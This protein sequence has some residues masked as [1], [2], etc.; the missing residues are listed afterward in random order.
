MNDILN[1]LLDSAQVWQARQ[2]ASQQ[3]GR[4]P[5]G[6]PQL[7]IQLAGGWPQAG[8]I[9]VL[10]GKSGIG[11]LQ[12]LLPLLR[13]CMT[14]GPVLWINPPFIPYA[15]ALNHQ[16]ISLRQ[17]AV[18]HTSSREDTLWTLEHSLRC[19]AVSLVVAWTNSLRSA[20]LRRVQLAAETRQCPCVLLRAPS[21]AGSS[22][23]ATL[24]LL[25][26]SDGERLQVNILKRRGSWP[27]SDLQ[28]PLTNRLP[29][30][31]NSNVISGPWASR[32]Q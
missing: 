9:E 2:Q 18:V 11:E 19:S 27:V 29:H 23:P 22:S 15:P 32:I 12:L 6:F 14:Q 13:Q 1:Q 30:P 8:L 4:M 31:D 17:L 24:R 16:S 25:L 7:D 26:D 3:P 20:Q 5:T 28:L 10:A 21:A